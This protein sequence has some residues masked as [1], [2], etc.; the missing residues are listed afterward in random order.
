[1][2]ARSCKCIFLGSSSVQ[3]GYRC[4]SF[5]E[6][7]YFVSKDVTF[8]ENIFF[9]KQNPNQGEMSLDP[10]KD[11]NFQDQ[12]T[13]SNLNSASNLDWEGLWHSE[14][15]KE[16]P[17]N[18]SKTTDLIPQNQASIPSEPTNSDP[19]LPD[20]NEPPHLPNSSHPEQT[21]SSRLMM[22]FLKTYS[23]KKVTYKASDMETST[24]HESNPTAGNEL[25]LNEL[26]IPIAL[27]KGQRSYTQHPILKFLGYSHLSTPMQALVTHLSKA[28]IPKSI[29]EALQN[30]KWKVVVIGEMNALIKNRTWEAVDQPKVKSSVGCR[31]VFI[32]S[33]ERMDR[34][35]A[36]RRT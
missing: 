28:E 7:K 36:T 3:K 5:E 25:T 18:T 2:D 15:P 34:L 29:D 31:W 9:F 4:Y 16:D 22:P 33:I 13:I 10:V 26:D 32:I 24:H 23:R 17:T 19:I 8:I 11:S 6:I 30:P 21:P 12:N 35:N 27:K 1:M 14:L 20:P